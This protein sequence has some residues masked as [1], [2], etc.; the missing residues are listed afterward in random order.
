MESITRMIGNDYMAGNKTPPAVRDRIVTR[1]PEARGAPGG[2]DGPSG[3][4]ARA[5]GRAGGHALWT[6]LPPVSDAPADGGEQR[7]VGRRTRHG[8]VRTAPKP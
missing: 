7:L 8:P 6:A 2:I 4:P 3:A 5:V 1:T